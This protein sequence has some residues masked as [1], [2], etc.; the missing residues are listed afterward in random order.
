M[1]RRMFDFPDGAFRRQLEEFDRM[2][3][4]MNLF[5]G[6]WMGTP[7]FERSGVFPLINLSESK[8]AFFVRAELPGVKPGELEIHATGTSVSL[9]GERKIPEEKI[10]AKYHRREREAGKFSRMI[11][12]G[13]EIDPERVEA[14]MDNGILTIILPKA[15]KAKPR[16]ITI[17]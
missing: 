5:G 1:I 15:E 6:R 12:L 4:Q 3:Q 14:R 2:R 7:G 17:K 16:Q 9:T 11:S 13:T 8:E 10:N